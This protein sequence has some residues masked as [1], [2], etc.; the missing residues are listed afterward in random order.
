M[1]FDIGSIGHSTDSLED[2]VKRLQAV[3]I[4]AIADVRSVPYS[5]RLPWFGR[6]S[7]QKNLKGQGISYVWMGNLL[8]G[9]PDKK[10]LFTPE[11]RA[12]YVAMAKEE[13]FQ[14]GLTRL[15]NGMSKFRI[16]MMCSE[17]D[18]LH[19]HRCLL[20]GRALIKKNINV[21]HFTKSENHLTQK[22]IE[23]LLINKHAKKNK[24]K[25]Y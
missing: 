22:D 16:A 21:I 1:Q 6:E 2:F 17:A 11:G 3:G 23:N 14:N 8:G 15:M 20:V 25:R 12:D 5:G 13:T 18:P 7:L 24:F 10:D 19:C 9:R 4:T